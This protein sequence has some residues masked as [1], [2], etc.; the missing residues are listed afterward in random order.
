VDPSCALSVGERE[1]LAPYNVAFQSL[2]SQAVGV[3]VAAEVPDLGIGQLMTL[4]G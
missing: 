1:R 2:L 3:Y 4:F